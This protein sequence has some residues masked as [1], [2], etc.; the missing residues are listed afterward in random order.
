MGIRYDSD[1]GDYAVTLAGAPDQHFAITFGSQ[2]FVSFEELLDTMFHEEHHHL[3]GSA[4]E[5][6]MDSYAADCTVLAMKGLGDSN[7]P[8]EF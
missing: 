5:G 4:D 1:L 7:D 3:T 2:A 6:L 8:V